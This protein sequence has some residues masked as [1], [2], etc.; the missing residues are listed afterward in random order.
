[1]RAE[2][3]HRQPK[4]FLQRL[5]GSQQ[6]FCVVKR[7]TRTVDEESRVGRSTQQREDSRSRKKR[8][9]GGC[10]SRRLQ[11]HF[12]QSRPLG[13]RLGRTLFQHPGQSAVSKV[14]MGHLIS[15]RS[16]WLSILS[17]SFSVPVLQHL[18][19]RNKR[20]LCDRSCRAISF[21]RWAVCCLL[22][23]SPHAVVGHHANIHTHFTH[24]HILAELEDHVTGFQCRLRQPD[25]LGLPTHVLCTLQPTCAVILPSTPH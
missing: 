13:G 10:S 12:P 14:V 11:Y 21:D 8:A 16:N 22:H 5:N 9:R 6:L 7:V 3:V 1:M 19:W 17:A 2:D 15:R 20:L 18:L 23:V 24:N 4:M 25:T